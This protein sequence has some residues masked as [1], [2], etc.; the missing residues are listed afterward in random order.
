MRI[1]LRDCGILDYF[2]GIAG[3]DIPCQCPLSTEAFNNRCILFDL[4]SICYGAIDRSSITKL[5]KVKTVC[6]LSHYIVC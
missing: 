4:R 2:D 6:F 1:F 3:L 5:R